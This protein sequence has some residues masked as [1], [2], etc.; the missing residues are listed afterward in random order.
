[1]Y[2]QCGVCENMVNQPR[3]RFWRCQ[4][5][6]DTQ[7]C[8]DCFLSVIFV[9]ASCCPFCRESETRVFIP[10]HYEMEILIELFKKI[11]AFPANIPVRH[12]NWIAGS[13]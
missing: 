11:L 9:G 13:L 5:P 10:N 6:Y 2:G 3:N 4:H 1:M 12:Q 7:L 8:L